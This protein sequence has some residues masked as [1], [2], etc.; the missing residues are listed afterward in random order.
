VNGPV[1]DQRIGAFVPTGTP[2]EMAAGVNT[3]VIATLGDEK[4]R[5]SFAD[6]AQEPVGGT[7]EQYA[8]LVRKD[9]EK[10]ARL[11]NE[12]DVKVE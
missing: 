7:A 12:L 4:V 3:A 1:I 11:V 6:R 2:P 5:K 8:R 10:C 9:C